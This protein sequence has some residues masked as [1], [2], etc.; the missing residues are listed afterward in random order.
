MNIMLS[1]LR[2]IIR[3]EILIEK[4]RQLKGPGAGHIIV[5]K[6]G[7]EYRVLALRLYGRYDI[8]KGK[9]EKNEDAYAAALRETEEESGITSLSYAWG[10]SSIQIGQLTVWLAETSQDP[11]IRKNP[12]TGIWEH[13]EALWVSWDQMR[14]KAIKY[15][16][17]GVDWAE[18]LVN[19]QH[20]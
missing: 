20:I 2:K 6:F 4:R 5:R 13:H 14:K 19:E 15:L 3:E 16:V 17:P 11:V 10:K 18:S 1:S 12:N 7:N 9:I 8:P